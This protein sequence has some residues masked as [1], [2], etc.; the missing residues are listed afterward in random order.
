MAWR[1]ITAEEA[2]AIGKSVY[3]EMVRPSLKGAAEPI[4]HFLAVDYDSRDWELDERLHKAARR[5]RERKPRAD[6][7]GFR[8]GFPAAF[9]T[10]SP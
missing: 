1:D 2:E 3:E 6:V 4:G 10:L 8:V 7:Y 5:L 9:E